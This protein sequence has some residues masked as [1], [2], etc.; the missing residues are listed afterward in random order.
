MTSPAAQTI[1]TLPAQRA[2]ALSAAHPGQQVSTRPTELRISRAPVSEP[3]PYAPGHRPVRHLRIVQSTAQQLQL[4]LAPAARPR[5]RALADNDF[6]PQRT[7]E[8][9]LPDLDRFAVAFSRAAAEVLTG[10]RKVEQLHANSSPAVLRWLDDNRAVPNRAGRLPS[11]PRVRSVSV[12]RVRDG[13][14]EVTALVQRG[15]RLRAMTAR[16]LGLDG[17]WQCVHLGIV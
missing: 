7:G 6:G 9:D 4:D 3:P 16:L 13:V 10:H 12:C 8:A 14:A 5:R 15:P 17:R 2:A 1:P 11:P